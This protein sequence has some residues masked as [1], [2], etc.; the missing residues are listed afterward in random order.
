MKRNFTLDAGVRFYYMTPTQSEGDQVAAFEPARV[1]SAQAPLL[2]QPVSTPQGR[3]A[4][5]P[6]TGEILPHVYVGRL[7]PDSGNFIN[8]MQVYDGT[9]QDS[10]PFRVAP[11][12]SF[13]WDVTGDGKTAI[14]GG[15]GDFLRPLHTTTSF[16]I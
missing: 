13:A 9:P 10:S 4:L 16:S 2:Y 3:R 1:D 8:G 5:N 7:V 6:L 15:G 14:R 12:L 11:R